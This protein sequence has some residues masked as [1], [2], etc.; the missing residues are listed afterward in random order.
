LK[1]SI[2]ILTQYYLPETGAPQNRLSALAN[3]LSKQEIDVEILTALPNYP[4]GKV[5]DGYSKLFYSN[6]IIEDIQVHRGWI[7]TTSEKGVIKRLLNYFSFVFTSLWLALFKLKK[8]DYVFCESPPLFLGITARWICILKGSRLIF[9]VSDLWPESAEKL[10]IITSSLFLKP[11]YWLEKRLYKKSYLITG[12]TQ[13]ICNSINVRH[14]NK[15]ILWLPNGINTNEKIIPNTNWRDENNF[16]SS[17]FLVIYAGI[18][19]HAQALETIIEAAKALKHHTHIKL[20]FFGDGPEK[21]KLISLKAVHQCDNVFFFGSV[22]KS[23]INQIVS[24]CDLGIVHLK[25]IPLFEGAI[26]SKIFEYVKCQVPVLLGAKGEVL[27]IF[28][29]QHQAAIPFEQENPMDLKSKIEWCATNTAALKI[30]NENAQNLVKVKFNTDTIFK[31][32]IETL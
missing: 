7:Y 13:G 1:K 16:K 22:T 23:E 3:Y 27:D 5:Y 8:F 17:D 30:T 21:E 19:G 14:P 24:C 2:L 29:Q 32:L 25:N 15:K 11:A 12:Q 28:V 6:E 10:G 26:P 20:L 9:N 4:I 31:G 18:L